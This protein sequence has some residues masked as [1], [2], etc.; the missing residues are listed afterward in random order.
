[1]EFCIKEWLTDT[2]S[3]G[4]FSEKLAVTSYKVHLADLMAWSKL[5]EVVNTNC[6]KILFKQAEYV[7]F[8]PFSKCN[9]ECKA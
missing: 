6:R 8:F 7:I 3:E 9:T 4:P 5:D 2:V 1:M